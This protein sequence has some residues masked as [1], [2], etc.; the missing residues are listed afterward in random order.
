M[1]C[2]PPP[3]STFRGCPARRSGTTGPTVPE[4]FVAI[5]RCR[6]KCPAPRD[7]QPRIVQHRTDDPGLSSAAIRRHRATCPAPPD[8]RSRGCS[9]RSRDAERNV[10]HHGIGDPGSS[11]TGRT[12][13]VVRRGDPATP[14]DVS[15]TTGPTVPRLLVAIPRCRAKRPASPDRRS[16]L[17]RRRPEGWSR[18]VR[19]RPEGWSGGDGELSGAVQGVI[20]VARFGPLR[21]DGPEVAGCGLVSGD[22]RQ[23]ISFRPSSLPPIDAQAGSPTPR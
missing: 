1:S 11:S 12:I 2:P 21:W 9:W 22:M 13:W 8:R 10:Q 7:R 3:K 15:G 14:G 17:V 16:R 4:L 19:R 6:A 23:A 20:G 5:P 18:L